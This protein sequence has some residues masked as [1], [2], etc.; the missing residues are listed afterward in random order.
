ME[1]ENQTIELAFMVVG[2]M[3][4][5]FQK[6]SSKL[7]PAR[8][9]HREKRIGGSLQKNWTTLVNTLSHKV[10]KSRNLNCAKY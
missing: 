8:V 1:L 2:I 4:L 6:P 7:K 9:L 5:K 3:A 10:R